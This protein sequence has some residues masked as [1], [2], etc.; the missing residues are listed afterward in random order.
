MAT[1]FFLHFQL[2]SFDSTIDLLWFRFKNCDCLLLIDVD[3]RCGTFVHGMDPVEKVG[4][5]RI[6]QWNME[7]C[8]SFSFHFLDGICRPTTDNSKQW[9]T[10]WR[11]QHLYGSKHGLRI[12]MVRRT[13]DH[14]SFDHLYFN[15]HQKFV[16]LSD[17]QIIGRA[18]IV[19]LRSC[20]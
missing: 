7:Y 8:R 17:F 15:T 16:L 6:F 9:S 13:M 20:K 10:V 3:F 12:L 11:I 2:H 1:G 19:G 18:R 5:Q 4:K 14:S